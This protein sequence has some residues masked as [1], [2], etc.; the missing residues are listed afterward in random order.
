MSGILDNKKRVIDAL[1]TF[2]GRRQMASGDLRIEYVSFSDTGTYYSK[3]VVSGS[4]DAT[5][6]IF[7]EACNL[8]QDQ[9]TFEAD[10]GGRLKPFRNEAGIQIKDGQILG[11]EYLNEAVDVETLQIRAVIE[12]ELLEFATYNDG[13]NPPTYTGYDHNPHELYG[14]EVSDFVVG[15]LVISSTPSTNGHQL[16]RVIEP[17]VAG[18]GNP[19]YVL[20]VFSSTI[21]VWEIIDGTVYGGTIWNNESTVSTVFHTGS[22]DKFVILTG[23]EFSSQATSLL[24]MSAENFKHLQLLGTNDLFGE[25]NFDVGNADITFTI[26]NERPINQDQ[27]V[28]NINQIDSLF[29]DIR[30][31]RLQNFAY[32]PPVNR[33]VDESIDKSDNALMSAYRLGDYQPWG[34]KKGRQLSL[35]QIQKELS[36]FER[37][38]FCKTIRFD[39]TSRDNRLLS[40]FFEKSHDRLVKLDVIDY[41]QHRSDDIEHPTSH[42]FF[43]GKVLIDNKNTHTFI[44]LFTLVFD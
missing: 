41:G 35:K 10:D 27:R 34:P 31:S 38:G 33:V 3:D 1:L 6:R 13:I 30:L 32:L 4:S 15:D 2:E 9:I 42:V 25:N 12:Q 43:V 36:Q 23:N 40:Q 11:Y 14:D 24:Q 39:P 5:S 18:E 8:P 22:L 44:H 7:L 28:A 21:T 37:L 19:T 17:G 26:T 16:F 29:N 20:E